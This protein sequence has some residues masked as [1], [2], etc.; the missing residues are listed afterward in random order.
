MS[1]YEFFTSSTASSTDLVQ[2]LTHPTIPIQM[3]T[4]PMN[5]FTIPGIPCFDPQF[6]H[7]FA[8]PSISVLQLLQTFS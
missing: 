8:F 6:G 4:N 2:L 3:I 5:S 1:L 7:F